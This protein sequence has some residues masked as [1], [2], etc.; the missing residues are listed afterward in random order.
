MS[1]PKDVIDVLNLV[2]DVGTALVTWRAKRTF[3][4]G[5]LLMLLPD[6]EAVAADVPAAIVE[7]PR[8]LG[9]LDAQAIADVILK[10]ETIYAA[11]A[12]LFH[13]PPTPPP[14]T[15]SK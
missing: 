10:V 12:P 5:E 15:P 2:Q 13:A 7:L 9:A 1:D 14:T 11:W 6:F 4:L 8:E 3:D